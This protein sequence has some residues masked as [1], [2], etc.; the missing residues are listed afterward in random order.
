[1]STR[2]ALRQAQMRSGLFERRQGPD[3][4]LGRLRIATERD[5]A[6]RH[7]LT[8]HFPEPIVRHGK[9]IPRK[10]RIYDFNRW[11]RC[12]NNPLPRS[13]KGLSLIHILLS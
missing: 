4:I 5:R 6:D 10:S 1:M 3:G 8:W 9:Q 11:L 13:R 12:P 2:T 7:G